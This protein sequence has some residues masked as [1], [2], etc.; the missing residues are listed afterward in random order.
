MQD[1]KQT[2]LE[3]LSNFIDLTANETVRSVHYQADVDEYNAIP[4]QASTIIELFER[5]TTMFKSPKPR[6][7]AI[8]DVGSGIGSALFVLYQC[9][10]A[11]GATHVKLNGIEKHLEL[12]RSSRKYLDRFGVPIT[13]VEMH[14]HDLRSIAGTNGLE[15]LLNKTQFPLSA[16][17]GQNIVFL[18]RIFRDSEPQLSLEHNVF[19]F[20]RVGT[21]FL[22]PISICSRFSTDEKLNWLK[23]QFGVIKVTNDIFYKESL[24]IA[25]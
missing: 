25:K 21:V 2:L 20:S 22:M 13:N 5:A 8:V 24:G 4:T 17:S 14:T 3:R 11:T 23:K 19:K 9:G 10:I 15:L 1:L 12:I 18:T 7:F 16:T 6:A